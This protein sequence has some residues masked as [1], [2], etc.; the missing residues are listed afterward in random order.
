MIFLNKFPEEDRKL[1]ISKRMDDDIEKWEGLILKIKNGDRLTVYEYEHTLWL[2]R[3]IYNVRNLLS[4]KGKRIVDETLLPLDQQ[5]IENTSEIE[6][7]IRGNVMPETEL[8]WEYRIP[9]ILVGKKKKYYNM[10]SA[11]DQKQISGLL[12][13][14]GADS[15]DYLIDHWEYLITVKIN[16]YK[17]NLDDYKNDI[18][19]RTLINKL[20]EL[21][22]DDGKKALDKV[23]KLLDQE[24]IENTKE[25]DEPL[26]GKPSKEIWWFYRIPKIIAGNL[27]ED[28]ISSGFIG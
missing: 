27:K 6:K 2:R 21:V 22:S 3:L 14:Y 26:L 20:R 17:L 24:F 19:T 1:I 16:A 5:F 12:P 8:W 13:K 10:F 18:Y 9:K 15:L 4:D 28:L 7:P 23:M 11:E 25:I